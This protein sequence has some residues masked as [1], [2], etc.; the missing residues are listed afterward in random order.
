MIRHSLLRALKK[1]RY[2]ERP[3]G[4]Y[5]M[6]L[7]DYCHFTSP[8]RRYPDLTVHRMLKL[9]TEGRMAEAARWQGRMADIAADT[10]LRESAAVSAER[11]ADSIMSAAWISRHLGEAFNGVVSSVTSWGLYVALPNGAEG[12]V[13]ISQLDDYF[14][15]DADRSRLIGTA[16]GITFRLGDRVRV[17]AARVNVPLGEI[18]FDLLP[19]EDGEY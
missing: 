7:K 18:N 19:V 17:R 9:L 14:E 16:T 11:Q 10:S 8:I 15:Y 13:H 12:L 5:A 2:C 1:A 4:H 6:A 3:L